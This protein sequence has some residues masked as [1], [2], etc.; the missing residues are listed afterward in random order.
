MLLGSVPIEIVMAL[1][2]LYSMLG[3]SRYVVPSLR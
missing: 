2:F 1:V 3:W